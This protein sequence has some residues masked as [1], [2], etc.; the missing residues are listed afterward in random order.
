MSSKKT[1]D[2]GTKI[3]IPSKNNRA[4]VAPD[5]PDISDNNAQT[6]IYR[7]NVLNKL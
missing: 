2:D 4:P 1:D 5:S 6:K 7:K 3:Y